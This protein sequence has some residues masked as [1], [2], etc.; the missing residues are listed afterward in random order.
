MSLRKNGVVDVELNFVYGNSGKR[1]TFITYDAHRQGENILEGVLGNSH[2]QG[3][4]S[5]D[6][7]W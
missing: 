1:S 6:P 3:K 2:D 4:C 5:D 7:S